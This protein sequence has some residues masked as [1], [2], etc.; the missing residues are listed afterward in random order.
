MT[1]T[2]DLNS[3]NYEDEYPD[4][5]QHPANGEPPVGENGFIHSHRAGIAIGLGVAVLGGAATVSIWATGSSDKNAPEAYPSHHPTS[6]ANHNAHNSVAQKPADTVSPNTPNAVPTAIGVFPRTEAQL[7]NMQPMIAKVDSKYPGGSPDTVKALYEDVQLGTQTGNLAFL[8]TALGDYMNNADGI[9]LQHD[10]AQFK[11]YFGLPVNAGKQ[12]E[13]RFVP[14]DIQHQGPEDSTTWNF[15]TEENNTST[16]T[17]TPQSIVLAQQT[18][19]DGSK[20]WV[21]EHTTS[22]APIS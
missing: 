9:I 3:R 8:R 21:I 10:V 6:T 4:Q 11:Q 5:S 16:V 20:R 18:D 15:I 22:G 17:K 13:Y 2:P 7:R 1:T 14:T 19:P 12:L